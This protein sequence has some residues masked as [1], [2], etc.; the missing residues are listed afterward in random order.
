[1]MINHVGIGEIHFLTNLCPSSADFRHHAVDFQEIIRTNRVE[2]LYVS[3]TCRNYP[4]NIAMEIY[5]C[6]DDFP[7]IAIFRGYLRFPEAN[8]LNRCT[9]DFRLLQAV[10]SPVM[11]RCPCFMTVR[12]ILYHYNVFFRRAS[13]VMS[14]H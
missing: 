10:A 1:M 9:C 12:L 4:F 8:S 7:T 2:S 14:F 5:P 6:A 13:L 3:Q 11:D